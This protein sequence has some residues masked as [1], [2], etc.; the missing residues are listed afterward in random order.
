M[1]EP[2]Q[3]SEEGPGPAAPPL[4]PPSEAPPAS[5]SGSIEQEE[6]LKASVVSPQAPGTLT[7]P[8]SADGPPTN[9]SFR[10]TP[11][12]PRAPA[13]AAPDASPPTPHLAR[14]AAAQSQSDARQPRLLAYNPTGPE[15]ALEVPFPPVPGLP[16][17]ELPTRQEGAKGADA[18]APASAG[19]PD[20]QQ[21]EDAATKMERMRRGLKAAKTLATKSG[22]SARERS[23]QLFLQASQVEPRALPQMASNAA[24][25]KWQKVQSTL[26]LPVQRL[27]EA[28]EWKGLKLLREVPYAYCFHLGR[29]PLVFLMVYIVLC[30][31]IVGMSWRDV[32]ID[33]DLEVY[34]RVD[35]PASNAHAQY[36]DALEH[37]NEEVLQNS[38]LES[39]SDR[40]AFKL[41][42]YFET[43]E[44]A[45]LSEGALREIRLLESEIRSWPGWQ[46]MC[47]SAD[48]EL[49]FRCDPGESLMNY[50][51]PERTQYLDDIYD[52]FHLSFTGQSRERLAVSAAVAYLLEGRAT[53]LDLPKFLPE[54]VGDA[55]SAEQ[56]KYLRSVFSFTVPPE[57][58]W[59]DAYQQVYEEFV[60]DELFPQL[61][62]IV[63]KHKDTDPAGDFAQP[64]R[65]LVYFRG[66]YISH[67][68]VVWTLR[69]DCR[70]ALGA[71]VLVWIVSIL[72]T[73]S[74]FIG[75]AVVL[76]VALVVPLTYVFVVVEKIGL[77]SFLGIFLVVGLGTDALLYANELWRQSGEH[78]GEDAEVLPERIA[79]LFIALILKLV[80]EFL[81]ALAFLV[82]LSSVMR[83]MREFGLFMSISMMV[84]CL[85]TLTV[86]VPCLVMNSQWVSPTLRRRMPRLTDAVLEP[87][88]FQFPSRPLA[89]A[90]LRIVRMGKFPGTKFIGAALTLA[91]VFFVATLTTALLSDAQGLPEIFPESHQHSA[92]RRVSEEF[93]PTAIAETPPANETIVCGPGEVASRSGTCGLHWCESPLPVT[94][95]FGGNLSVGLDNV[96]RLSCSCSSRDID[97]AHGLFMMRSC[98]MLNITAHVSGL[99]LATVADSDW[100]QIWSQYIEDKH[101]RQVEHWTADVQELPSLVFENWE[102]G[103][104]SVEP[105][106]QMP[107]ALVKRV[108]DDRPQEDLQLHVDEDCTHT[109]LC[110]CG[111]RTCDPLDG[112]DT[113]F[114]S[115]ARLEFD[116]DNVALS[117]SAEA[118]VEQAGQEEIESTDTDS[119]RESE[120]V[121]VF[122]IDKQNND[123][124]EGHA[125]W[126]FDVH[127]DASSPAAQRAMVAMCEDYPEHLNVVR[128]RCWILAFRSWLQAR[129][130]RFPTDRFADFTEQVKYFLAEQP[131]WEVDM[132]FSS[133]GQMLA[134]RTTFVVH[135]PV[136]A[137]TRAIMR[138]RDLWRAY[139]AERNDEAATTASGAWPTSLAWV[140]AEAEQEAMVSAWI[141]CC[142]AIMATVIAGLIYVRDA[143]FVLMITASALVGCCGVA[144]FMFC[145]FQWQVGPWEVLLLTIFLC[146]SVSPA[147]R[148]GREYFQDRTEVDFSLDESISTTFPSGTSRSVPISTSTTYAI[149]TPGQDDLA[150]PSQVRPQSPRPPPSP[151]QASQGEALGDTLRSSPRTY[152]QAAK[153][154]EVNSIPAALLTSDGKEERIQRSVYLVTEAV[155]AMAVKTI[156]C[157]ILLLPCEFTFFSRL[158]AVA[159]VLPFFMVPCILMV[160]PATLYVLGPT[161]FK[162]DLDILRAWLK[163]KASEYCC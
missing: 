156:A 91:M 154:I 51:W 87:R 128:A 72:F 95:G 149:H 23:G 102:S 137:S 24:K 100:K 43:R 11:V 65:T 58:P 138:E 101:S 94:S 30:T 108:L 55:S 132:W 105:F 39:N 5:P 130:E 89:D 76:T 26:S 44:G 131:Q 75:T 144:F 73:Q 115:N 67:Y 150:L 92:G 97:S 157:G 16:G 2:T 50:I 93:A 36:L 46:R 146:Y 126:Q 68:E 153:T 57:E 117:T 90:L 88:W 9:R 56:T 27:P 110:H 104:T 119:L 70:L 152:L 151:S 161:R 107:K 59:Q 38:S 15:L 163:E 133:A 142:F 160:L 135:Q 134:T 99:A 33:S 145:I 1:T 77:A 86:F 112:F 32:V 60:R 147:F 28:P 14:A 136:D 22:L 37:Q 20:S 141:V 69:R 78:Y 53:P 18:A 40:P 125:N 8:S 159:I 54:D 98:P 80:P 129:G 158:G 79:V 123:F 120:V 66:D 122:G 124:L 49:R 81:V 162:P 34:R 31:I 121:V 148:M 118:M 45:I 103:H 114:A 96:T 111:L 4:P 113:S 82:Q 3:A 12:V 143:G 85:L 62:S 47:N 155:M 41:Y 35:G 17:Q 74:V 6:L 63:E 21:Q 83:P 106:T 139:T 140:E 42:L 25:E 109:V 64:M 61:Q 10:A 48:A 116:A 71:F 52:H 127:F 7:S 19:E 13:A 84:S 29:F